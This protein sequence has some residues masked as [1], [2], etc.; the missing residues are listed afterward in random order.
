LT[1]EFLASGFNIIKE[2]YQECFRSLRT[3]GIISGDYLERDSF[4]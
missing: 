2:E 4:D 3:T 1:E